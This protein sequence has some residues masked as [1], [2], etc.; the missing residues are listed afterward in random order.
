MALQ[1]NIR[2]VVCGSL[3]DGDE[4]DDTC[5][6]CRKPVDERPVLLILR[7]KHSS[8]EK[9][10]LYKKNFVILEMEFDHEDCTGSCSVCKKHV[11]DRLDIIKKAKSYIID[12]DGMR[13]RGIILSKYIMD[14]LGVYEWED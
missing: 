7:G 11:Q 4:Q 13:C 2:C 3:F 14:L 8:R 9:Y 12:G 1:R 6:M 10:P 5:S